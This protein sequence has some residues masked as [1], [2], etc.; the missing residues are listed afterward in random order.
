[1]MIPTDKL[2]IRFSPLVGERLERVLSSV[3][4]DHDEAMAAVGADI[5]WEDRSDDDRALWLAISSVEVAQ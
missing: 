1:M 5:R 3:A 2:E 4:A